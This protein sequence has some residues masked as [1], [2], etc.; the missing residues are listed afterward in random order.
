MSNTISEIMDNGYLIF[1]KSGHYL[2]KSFLLLITTRHYRNL[3][4][5]AALRSSRKISHLFVLEMIVEELK[6]EYARQELNLRPFGS[7]PNA[8]STELRARKKDYGINKLPIHN[9]LLFDISNAENHEP[10]Q[11]ETQICT[12]NP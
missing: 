8:L 5:K 1:D 2:F 6:T 4:S 9:K 7:E 10:R 12:Q 3:A 11:S